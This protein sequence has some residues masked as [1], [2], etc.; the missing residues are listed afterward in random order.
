ML[1]SI[2]TIRN[3]PRDNTSGK[4]IIK[5]PKFD[6]GTPEEWIAF[7]DLVQKS[8]VGQNITT[9]PSIYKCIENVLKGDAKAEFPQQADLVDSRTVANFTRVMTTMT[10]HVFPT[11]AYHDQI[12][13][14]QRYLRKPPDMKLRSFTTRLI[15]LNTY[16]P[17]FSPDRPC[18]LVTF[19]PDQIFGKRKW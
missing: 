12:R 19:I 11:Y 18:Q 8:L 3:T 1:W 9:G 14:M 13:Y 15:Q 17:N 4:Y 2:L 6:S 10:V 16:L 5:N 7:L